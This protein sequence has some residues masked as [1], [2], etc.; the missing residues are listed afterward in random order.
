M[1]PT[2]IWGNLSSLV[3]AGAGVAATALPPPWG[4]VA[5]GVLGLLSVILTE[6]NRS[7]VTPCPPAK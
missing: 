3:A 4:P 2:R 6:V 5:S 1:E 7:K